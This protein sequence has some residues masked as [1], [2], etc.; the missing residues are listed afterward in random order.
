MTMK[1][2]IRDDFRPEEGE[3]D[4]IGPA[5]WPD[6]SVK[7]AA[8]RWIIRAMPDIALLEAKKRLIEKHG[9]PPESI[10]VYVSRM[11]RI[12][13]P[14]GKDLTP[15]KAIKRF[16][17][18]VH[19]DPAQ[20]TWKF[21]LS[22]RDALRDSMPDKPLWGESIII[23]LCDPRSDKKSLQRRRVIKVTEAWV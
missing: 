4:W 23:D 18:K 12:P 13:G 7:K 22:L 6:L 2:R 10:D 1:R 16:T 11:M 9:E 20:D 15:V 8:D 14:R 5:R 19:G 21:I 17:H 3:G